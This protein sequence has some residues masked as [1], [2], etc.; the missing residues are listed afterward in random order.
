M[1]V[2][3]CRKGALLGGVALLAASLDA[4]AGDQKPSKL[5][6]ATA[7]ETA[8]D[9][10]EQGKLLRAREELAVCQ[11]KAC[12]GVVKKECT[13]AAARV[14]EAIPTLGVAVRDES[15][16]D[17]PAA[18][19]ELDGAPLGAAP[20]GKA[21]EVDP[22]SH[23]LRVSAPGFVAVERKITMVEGERARTVSVEL[24]REKPPP[25]EKPSS[26]LE[27]P[28]AAWLLGGVGVLGLGG[29]ALFGLDGRA[30]QS[31]LERCK[32]SCAE[33]DIDA[34]QRR[35]L[36][37]DISL[38]VGVVALG[39]AAYLVATS[40]PAPPASETARAS[41]G[42]TLAPGVAGAVVQGRY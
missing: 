37:A 25:R 20:D 12:P 2:I 9:L 40:E 22:G 42:L 36:F 38:G 3:C 30:R 27:V 28:T 26:G 13:K 10:I 8:Q 35:Y 15:G 29:F 16:A 19:V 31:D 21:R 34:V 11:H 41:F 17:V 39:A 1:P 6:C 7:F 33:E 5:A 18:S 4:R 32:P 23:T 24:A 14:S